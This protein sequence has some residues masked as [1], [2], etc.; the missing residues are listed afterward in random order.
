MKR[1]LSNLRIGIRLSLGFGIILVFLALIVILGGVAI[2]KNKENLVTGLNQSK[3]KG[4]LAATMK[5]AVLEGGIAMRNVGLQ[6]EVLDMQREETNVA[7]QK[8]RYI[9]ALNKLKEIG[10]TDTEK[11]VI[12]EIEGLEQKIRVPFKEALDNALA[13]NNEGATKIITKRINPLTQQEVE[14]I[15]KLISLQQA[16]ADAFLDSSVASDNKLMALLFSSGIATVVIGAICAWGITRS[17]TSPLNE[18]VSVAY[19]VATGDLTSTIERNSKDEIGQ[20]F[21][22]LQQMNNSLG[23]IVGNVR[24]GT[25]AIQTASCEIASG[26]ADLSSRTESQASS[27]EMTVASME[28]ITSTVKKNAESTKQANQLVMSASDLATR[29]GQMVG[30]VIDTMGSIKESSHKIV[31]IIGVIDSISF[32]TNIL[33][34]N[35]AVEAARAGEQ[36][37]GFAVVAAEV[38]AL[39]QR[40]ASAAKEVKSLVNDSVTKINT[41]GNLVDE[42]GRTMNEIVTSI[43]STTA[44]IS[45]IAAA[46]QEQ[47]S[48]IMEINQAV[49]QMDHITQQNSALVEQIAAAAEEMKCQAAKL[50]Q[51]V[52]V[53][54]LKHEEKT[55]KNALL[56]APSIAMTRSLRL[57]V[58]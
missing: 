23:E 58:A 44:V 53:F 5:S 34:L 19:R 48:D 35:A 22:S 56:Q 38:R 41:G 50:V 13:F 6:T 21:E 37:R 40:V 9:E 24:T 12:E 54:K 51:A 30:Q 52:S 10:L 29:G 14:K 55:E 47:S 45:N 11:T 18:S 33:A 28:R 27:L 17:I 4:T 39:A 25:E 31:D 43:Q 2:T 49:V 3:A 42:T 15:D 16:S 8:K 7:V 26:N 1:Y 46:S 36:G 57:P 20:L 32:Q